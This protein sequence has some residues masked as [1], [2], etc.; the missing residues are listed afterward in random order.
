MSNINWTETGE[1]DFFF[2]CDKRFYL[3]STVEETEEDA[4]DK[5]QIVMK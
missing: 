1:Q 3:G 2:R 4:I 5:V